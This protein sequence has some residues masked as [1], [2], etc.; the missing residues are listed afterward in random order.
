VDGYGITRRFEWNAQRAAVRLGSG[1]T[2]QKAVWFWLD[3]VRREA[4]ESHLRTQRFEGSDGTGQLFSVEILDICG[5]SAEYCIK[6]EA[7]EIAALQVQVGRAPSEGDGTETFRVDPNTN[8]GQSTPAVV[9]LNAENG[10]EPDPEPERADNKDLGHRLTS[11]QIAQQ[12]RAQTVARLITELDKLK[13]QM[14]EDEKEYNE[15]SA[16]YPDFLAF[17]IAETRPDLKRKILAIRGSVRHI[18]LAQE[19]TAA[20]YGR[21]VSTIQE[22]WKNFKPVEFRRPK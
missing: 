17:K 5:L 13:P 7:D 18:L 1:E 22:D 21:E 4:P 16:Q 2:G 14:F 9:A 3:R 12:T 11:T 15:L 6:C 10:Q 20:H 8:S 19:L